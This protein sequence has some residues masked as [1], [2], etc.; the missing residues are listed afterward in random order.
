MLWQRL[1][2]P[3]WVGV[4]TVVV[5][6][7]FGCAGPRP[8]SGSASAP[9]RPPRRPGPWCFRSARRA[10][11]MSG[12]WRGLVGRANGGMVVHLGVV[13]LAV[14][15]HRGHLVPAS[16]R[17]GPAPGMPVTY[18]GHRF[19]FEGLRTVSHAVQLGRPGAGEGRRRRVR[20]RRDELR[21]R[22]GASG[23]PA[24][25]SGAVRRRLPD[26][27]R[28]RGLGASSGDLAIPNL[29]SGSVAIGWSSSRSSP[30]CGRAV[31]WWASAAF[32]HW[33]RARAA[34]PPI[35]P[36]PRRT[37]RRTGR[38]PPVRPRRD[39]GDADELDPDRV[40]RRWARPAA[41][42]VRPA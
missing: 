1:A 29:P 10:P 3:A 16:D 22:A 20:P 26:L 40:P 33:F 38:R 6:V 24:I 19:E 27:R 34:G 37:W 4:L 21:R 41:R 23:T 8:S 32:S 28:G 7:A 12:W 15:H 9:W 11:A 25:D 30:G 39:A 5:C 18:D 31:S 2:V 36:R 13:V 42:R 14:G 35:P 17:A